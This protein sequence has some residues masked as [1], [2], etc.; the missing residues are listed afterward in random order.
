[1]VCILNKLMGFLFSWEK[2]G[3]VKGEHLGKVVKLLAVLF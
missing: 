2:D 1:M 3:F